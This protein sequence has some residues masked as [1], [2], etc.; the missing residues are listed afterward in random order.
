MAA[1][2][3]ILPII[4]AIGG[5]GGHA[6][7][8]ANHLDQIAQGVYLDVHVAC[9]ASDKAV[10]F[11]VDRKGVKSAP[12]IKA[13]DTLCAAAAGDNT[14]LNRGNLLLTAILQIQPIWA[15]IDKD[16]TSK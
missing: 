2:L 9:A 6:L 14:L 16:E 10:D 11:V 1:P 12:V 5:W 8:A 13:A 4:G 7:T 15:L 3:I